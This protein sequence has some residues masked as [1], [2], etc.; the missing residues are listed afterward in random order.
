VLDTLIRVFFCWGMR[1]LVNGVGG[2]K[3]SLWTPLRVNNPT[4]SGEVTQ[5]P[6]ILMNTG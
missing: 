2:G 1:V 6:V 5:S 3:V 4:I